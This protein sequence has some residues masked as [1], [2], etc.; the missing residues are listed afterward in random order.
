VNPGSLGCDDR[1]LARFVILICEGG[2]VALDKRAV[3]YDD[4]PLYEAFER[5]EVPERHFLYRAFFGSR[6]DPD[7][8]G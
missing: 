4:A 3:S 8:G 2:R 5:R 6:F 7:T 1:A